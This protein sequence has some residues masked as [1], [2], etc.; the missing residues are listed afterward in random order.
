MPAAGLSPAELPPAPPPP[1]SPGI[2]FSDPDSGTDSVPPDQQQTIKICGKT[3]WPDPA[4]PLQYK[5]VYAV[6][7]FVKLLCKAVIERDAEAPVSAIRGMVNTGRALRMGF[8]NAGALCHNML[9]VILDNVELIEDREQTKW[10]T[11]SVGRP[12]E[13]DA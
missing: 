10:P 4:S 3:F 1:A 9:R 2:V 5:Q 7:L 11:N 13:L 6:A 8:G 12:P